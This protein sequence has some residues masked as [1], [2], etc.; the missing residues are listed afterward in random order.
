MRKMTAPSSRMRKLAIVVPTYNEAANVEAIVREIGSALRQVDYEII[1]ADDDSPD[2]TWQKAAE[3][4]RDNDRV[5]V[6]RR[7]KNRGL[8]AAVA[9][10]MALANSEFVAC[11]DADL[12]H[13]SAI[14]PS[15][16]AELQAGK[17]ITVGSRYI[18]GGGI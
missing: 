11:I 6:L 12:Q 4:S 17:T 1:I 18:A 15:M 3:L 9:D 10:G 2:L 16:L 8:A 13:D 7:K 14:L 5:R